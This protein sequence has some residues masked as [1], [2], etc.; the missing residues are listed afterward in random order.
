M[1]TASR[2]RLPRQVGSV[3]GSL[4]SSKHGSNNTGSSSSTSPL[5]KKNSGIT[6]PT[7]ASKPKKEGNIIDST[8]P[9]KQPITTELADHYAALLRQCGDAGALS[10]GKLLHKRIRQAGFETDRYLGNLLLQ[11]YGKCGA[12]EDAC[13]VFAH[14]PH[15]NV[16][17]WNL[18]MGAYIDNGLYKAALKAFQSMLTTHIV[19]D[20]ITLV[21]ALTACSTLLALAEGK[22]MHAYIRRHGFESNTLVG[23]AL[24]NLYAKCGSL[25]EARTMFDDLVVRDAILWN[26]M[27]VACAQNK[28][29]K[30]ALQ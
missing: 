21:G 11:M 14:M 27:I 18:M 1:A 8:I 6:A 26:A 20:A 5:T 16:F 25:T 10:E 19:P 24:V 23:T 13:L 15:K 29:G 4:S 3:K 9:R 17:T 30:E 28:R 7:V 2:G 22:W 12:L